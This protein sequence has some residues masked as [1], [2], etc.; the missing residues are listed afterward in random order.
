MITSISFDNCVYPFLS[1]FLLDKILI[2][3]KMPSYCTVEEERER[4]ET[5]SR[6]THLLHEVDYNGVL[7][8]DGQFWKADENGIAQSLGFKRG[9]GEQS[10]NKIH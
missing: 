1:K 9:T 10:C 4:E 7:G 3:S 6:G 2:N 8:S 5:P